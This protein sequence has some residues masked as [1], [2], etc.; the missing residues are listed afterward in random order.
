MA[1]DK[2]IISTLVKW[3]FLRAGPA[4]PKV[5]FPFRGCAAGPSAVS[6]GVQR[7]PKVGIC[8]QDLCGA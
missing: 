2:Y 4:W 7:P 8:S 3:K 5:P 1:V 6:A